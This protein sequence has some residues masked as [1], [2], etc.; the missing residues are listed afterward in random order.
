MGRIF[1]MNQDNRFMGSFKSVNMIIALV[2]LYFAFT[3]SV[4][5]NELTKPNA[6]EGATID[7][8]VIVQPSLSA[9]AKLGKVVFKNNC[10]SCHNKNMTTDLT[11]PAL[12]GVSERWSDYPVEDLYSWI[13]NS[14]KLIA[15][16]HPRAL[17]VAKAWDYSKMNSMEHLSNEDIAHLIEYIER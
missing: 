1:R 2:W 11:G 17:E 14:E 3:A 5:F 13:R 15:A 4:V 6:N 8:E 12:K 16:K 7:N 9:E 10:A